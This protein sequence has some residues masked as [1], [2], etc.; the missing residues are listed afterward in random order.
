MSYPISDGY[1]LCVLWD[2]QSLDSSSKWEDR[3]GFFLSSAFLGA[4]SDPDRF[5]ILEADPQ[6]GPDRADHGGV[7][8]IFSRIWRTA[9]RSS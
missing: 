3:T 4:A 2:E 5:A 8:P 7:Y 1:F 9:S 6:T